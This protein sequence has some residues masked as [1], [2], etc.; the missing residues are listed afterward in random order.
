VDRTGSGTCSKT[1]FN[2]NGVESSGHLEIKSVFVVR[3]FFSHP[4]VGAEISPSVNLTKL[5]AGRQG[6]DSPQGQEF[7]L[8]VIVSTPVLWPTQPPIKWVQGV[9]RPVRDD[10][11]LP[12]SVE[13]YL[14]SPIQVFIVRCLINQKIRLHSIEQGL[15]LLFMISPKLQYHSSTQLPSLWRV[16]CI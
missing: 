10:N 11:S 14:H 5:R 16:I 13:L 9:K 2:F 7:F 3:Y 6:L 15:Y 8:F 4:I 1:G 12:C